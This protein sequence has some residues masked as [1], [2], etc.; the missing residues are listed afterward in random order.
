MTTSSRS[1]LPG[2]ASEPWTMPIC[3]CRAGVAVAASRPASGLV[4]ARFVGEDPAVDDGVEAARW[5]AG[6]SG[7]R[8][9]TRSSPAARRPAP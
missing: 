1:V 5:T 6:W 8:T 3:H 4:G 9:V 7:V 2:I